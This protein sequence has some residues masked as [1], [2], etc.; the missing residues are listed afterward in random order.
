M[1]VTS[2]YVRSIRVGLALLALLCAHAAQADDARKPDAPTL[3]APTLDDPTL[4]RAYQDH[5]AYVATF[6]MPVL[7]ERCSARDPAYLAEAAP[8]Y[9]R[10]VNA[11]QD[12]IERGRLLTLSELA[13]D[14]TLQAYRTRVIEQR[15]GKLQTGSD[16]EVARMC[17]GALA[18]LR[19]AA[20]PG[21]WPSRD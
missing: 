15:L 17:R 4:N 13:P 7:I 21:E 8:L 20:L 3:D 19:G 14:E 10:F 9:F 18:V 12:R 1:S 16:E 5:V 2:R 11:H 6:A